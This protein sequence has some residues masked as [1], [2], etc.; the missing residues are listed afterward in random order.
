MT[1]INNDI[2]LLVNG[3]I[4]TGWK[5]VN[6]RRSIDI[7]ADSF[8]L[9]LTDNQAGE[10][11]TIKLGSPCQ[12]RIGGE[13]LITG[14]I[15]RIRPGYNSR[16]RTLIVS[17]RSK[18]ADLVDCSLPPQDT[19]SGQKINQ[20]LLQWANA[21]GKHF[22]VKAH[23]EVKDLPSIAN[24]VFAP[25]QTAYEFLELQARTAGVRLVSDS[26]GNMVISK[27]SKERVSTALVL[28]ENIEAAEGEFSQRD[29]FSHYHVLGSGSFSSFGDAESEILISG[30][31]ED[32]KTRYRPTVV[33]AGGVL[34]G[35]S[36]AKFRAEFQ[37]NIAYGR[38]R[39]ATYTVSGWYHKDGLWQP[40]TNVLVQDKWMGFTGKNGKGEWLM[41]GTVQFVLDDGGQRTRLTVMPAEAYDL[42]P[43][44]E[45]DEVG[46]W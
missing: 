15:D 42:I 4:Y 41:I 43:L 44:P 45:E 33:N 17:G 40:N 2:E 19:G 9:T 30:Q 6:V 11:R 1:K 3:R 12:V 14:F 5:G 31:A 7:F 34:S 23:S 27:T 20:T 36:E 32:L 25:E 13:K 16:S 24:A 22:N 26:D 37:R 39:Q 38:S 8:D 29:R 18:N 46:D 10:A 21:I 28:G 35:I